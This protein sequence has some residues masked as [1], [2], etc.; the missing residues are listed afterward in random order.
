VHIPASDDKTIGALS[1]LS[2]AIPLWL[3]FFILCIYI[4]N[5]SQGNGGIFHP[6]SR[7]LS[8]VDILLFLV[9]M[10]IIAAKA[11]GALSILSRVAPSG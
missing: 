3:I 2:R 10:R 9:H 1:I 8:L 6:Q 7:N 5:C 4:G 11:M